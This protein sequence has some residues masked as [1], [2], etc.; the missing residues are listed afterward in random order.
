VSL[1]ARPGEQVPSST[2]QVARASNPNG[3]TAMRVRDRLDGLWRDEDFAARSAS[4]SPRLQ[5]RRRQLRAGRGSPS[6]PLT[7]PNLAPSVQSRRAWTISSCDRPIQFQ[8]IANPAYIRAGQQHSGSLTVSKLS[9]SVPEKQAAVSA[10]ALV[11]GRG[12]FSR[13]V[14]IHGCSGRGVRT[15]TRSGTGLRRRGR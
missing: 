11:R 8:N 5:R 2:A 1:R 10:N 12:W 14:G 9:A 4:S 13:S 15:C 7:S 6:Y 3:T